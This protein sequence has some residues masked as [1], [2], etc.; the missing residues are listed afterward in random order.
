VPDE[1]TVSVQVDGVTWRWT[2]DLAAAAPGDEV[3]TVEPETGVVQFGDGVQGRR[4]PAGARIIV[5]YRHGGG[6]AGS[7]PVG[8]PAQAALLAPLERVHFFPGRL[9]TAEDFQAEQDYLRGRQRRHH[10]LLH[11]VGIVCGLEV[12]AGGT[13]VTVSPGMAIDAAGDEIIVSAPQLVP[14]PPGCAAMWLAV[15]YTET[16]VRPV[17]ISGVGTGEA[18]TMHTRVRE[19]FAFH[20]LS[21]SEAKP[22]GVRLARLTQNNGRWKVQHVSDRPAQRTWLTLCLGGA[23]LAAAAVLFPRSRDD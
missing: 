13:G 1:E 20:Y 9:L 11:G 19:G 14:F 22:H 3:F 17:P 10:L 12:T 4:P 15:S 6:G 18:M 5:S 2:S 16:A 23:L 7:V 8:D 21:V